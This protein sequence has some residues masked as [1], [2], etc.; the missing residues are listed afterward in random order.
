MAA[1]GHYDPAN[2]G[3]HLGPLGEGHKGDLPAL[4]VDPDGSATK[5][6]IA[7]RLKAS[8]VKGHSIVIHVGGD[9]YTDQPEPHRAAAHECLR[10]GEVKYD[11]C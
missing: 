5:D 1:C 6:L 4:T 10:R 2:T 9:N 7:P 3:K 8:D 11:N